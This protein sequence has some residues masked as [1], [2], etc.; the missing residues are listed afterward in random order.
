M[1]PTMEQNKRQ[2]VLQYLVE[3]QQ[4]YDVNDLAL[5]IE[6]LRAPGGCPWDREQTHKSIRNDL[7]EET[8]EVIEAIDT[9][10]PALMREELGDVLLQVLFHTQIAKEEGQF[11]FS[12]VTND[13]CAKLIHRHPHVFGSVIA[14]DTDT[15]LSNWDQI[16]GEEKHRLT[17]TDKLTSIPPMLP[18][19][20]RAAKVGKKAGVMDFPSVES[21][22]DK[23]E[24]ETKEVREAI[25]E[26]I[27]ER[28]DEEIGDLLLTVT[29]LARK[30]GVDP[31]GALNRATNKFIKR[32][33]LVEQEVLQSGKRM[34][35]LSV[36]Q[37]D[38]IWNKIKVL[39]NS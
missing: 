37:L 23:L 5:I 30:S 6:I 33:S 21:V 22:F 20:M 18:A 12:G 15:V 32:F 8:Y 29:S 2:E 1:N 17:V 38:D 26:G 34:E 14:E 7:I 27:P 28:M 31:E 11:D 16:K 36:N 24:E 3:K 39:Q 4:G 10:N 19:L 13:I 35:E 9:E 25:A